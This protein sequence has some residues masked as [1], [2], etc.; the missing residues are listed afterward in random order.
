[1]MYEELVQTG[2]FDKIC[3]TDLQQDLL[4]SFFGPMRSKGG[5][6]TNPTQEQFIGN[7][8]RIVLNKELTSSAL[9]NCDACFIKPSRSNQ[10]RFK[11][12]HANG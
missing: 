5:N 8:R 6:D 7:F 1:M 11:F 9:S 10:N 3:T 2:L 12:H 4:E